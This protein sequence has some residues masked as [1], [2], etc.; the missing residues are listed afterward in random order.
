MSKSAQAINSIAEGNAEAA[1]ESIESMS[2]VYSEWLHSANRVQA[3]VIRF[4]GDRFSKD[5]ALASR[6]ANCRQPDEFFRLQAQAVSEIAGDYMQESARI[7]ALFSDAS[8]EGLA[9]LAKS[10]RGK[11]A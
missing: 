11:A 2:H 3:E 10:T 1:K 4:I 5:L 9:E 7:F 8:R 6:F